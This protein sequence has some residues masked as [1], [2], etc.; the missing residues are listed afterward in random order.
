MLRSCLLA[1]LLCG[2]TALAQNP[3][4]ARADANSTS[5][6]SST[7]K[8][9]VVDGKKVVDEKTV[10]GKRTPGSKR[11]DVLLPPEFEDLMRDVERRARDGAKVSDR[12]SS[13]SSSSHRVQ[14]VNGKTVVDEKTVDGKVVPGSK[15]GA[16]PL[17]REFDELMRDVE[18]RARAGADSSRASDR[19]SSSSRNTSS[20]RD[21]SSSKNAGRSSRSG[22][23]KSGSK[24]AKRGTK[25][26]KRSAGPKTTSGKLRPYTRRR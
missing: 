10:N 1:F 13:R 19:K 15:R 18:R 3:A 4:E 26:V 7:H 24:Q 9:V 21:T 8:V 2:A 17:P 16:I 20:S 25:R 22:S 6:S 11:G 14:V 12:K 5:K 23:S